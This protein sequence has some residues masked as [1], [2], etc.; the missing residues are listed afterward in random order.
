[1]SDQDHVY[2]PR[3]DRVGEEDHEL[4]GL[5]SFLDRHSP[6]QSVE[7]RLRSGT[8]PESILDALAVVHLTICGS[9]PIAILLPPPPLPT[10]KT[11]VS[12]ASDHLTRDYLD[13]IYR[14]RLKHLNVYGN[15][16]IYFQYRRDH[17]LM[18]KHNFAYPC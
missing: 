16:R 9:A 17:A 4:V 8:I 11:T 14:S 18:T 3:G 7:L 15:G 1:M 10:P 12:G 13:G 6:L 2:E 5:S